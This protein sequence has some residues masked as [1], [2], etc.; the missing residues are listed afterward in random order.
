[1]SGVGNDLLK[2]RTI[3]YWKDK[4]RNGPGVYVCVWGGCLGRLLLIKLTIY[5]LFIYLIIIL[6]IKEE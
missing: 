6:L 2:Q 4:R 1:M 5:Y 3:N